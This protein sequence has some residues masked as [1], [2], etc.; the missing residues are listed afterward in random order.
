MIFEQ[1]QALRREVRLR[2]SNLAAAEMEAKSE[3]I[4]RQV[5]QLEEFRQAATV[6]LFASL[7]TEV[8][9]QR[10]MQRWGEQ[11]HLLLPIVHGDALL[12][13]AAADLKK[14]ALF[15]IL[16]P[17]RA[18]AEM[19][20]LDV[21]IVPGLAFDRSGN[22]LGRGKGYYDRFLKTVTNPYKIGVCFGCQLFEQIPH[23]EQDVKMDKVVVG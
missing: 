16:E 6:L 5:E 9:A 18:L 10:F 8:Q 2:L 15:G 22:R 13:G 7:P 4:W 17:V 12:V 14:S 3:A 1:K 23:D 21:A 11:K 19:P 20:P